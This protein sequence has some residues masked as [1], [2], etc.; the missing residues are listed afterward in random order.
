M[1]KIYWIKT[2]T[3]CEYTSAHFV[4]QCACVMAASEL[5]AAAIALSAQ[6]EQTYIFWI[7]CHPQICLL[8]LAQAAFIQQTFS[9]W[10]DLA[11]DATG[12]DTEWG[13]PISIECLAQALHILPEVL[14]VLLANL[15]QPELELCLAETALTFHHPP[16]EVNQK[17]VCQKFYSVHISDLSL[18]QPFITDEIQPVRSILAASG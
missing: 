6:P 2:A 18:A 4:N 7:E 12:H 11:A 15:T 10:Q 17:S 13:Y 3:Q 16:S 8:T 9:V 14:T 1:K 5:E